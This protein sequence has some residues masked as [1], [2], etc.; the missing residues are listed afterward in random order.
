MWSF[1]LIVKLFTIKSRPRD[2]IS[3]KSSCACPNK[4]TPQLSASLVCTCLRIYYEP[5]SAFKTR[6][7][8]WPALAMSGHS[9]VASNLFLKRWQQTYLARYV[10]LPTRNTWRNP[11]NFFE[12]GLVIL[13]WFL[14][15]KQIKLISKERFCA[16]PYFIF[17]REGT[18]YSTMAY[19]SKSRH[20]YLFEILQI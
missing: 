10:I 13:K 18:G 17:L 20:S 2:L 1:S 4:A 6:T 7:C 5:P 11:N 15:F 9:R 16:W 19:W 8:L 3:V 14:T 12:I